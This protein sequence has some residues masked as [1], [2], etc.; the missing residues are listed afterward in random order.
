[1]KQIAQS[2]LGNYTFQ[3]QELQPSR[4]NVYALFRRSIFERFSNTSLDMQSVKLT[5][6]R[7]QKQTLLVQESR[8][9]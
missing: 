1:M 4:D 5:Y 9:L 2:W 7:G 6:L 8:E 3:T